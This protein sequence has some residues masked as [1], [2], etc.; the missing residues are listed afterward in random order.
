[1]SAEVQTFWERQ[2]VSYTGNYADRARGANHNFRTRLALAVTLA[3]GHGGV[4]LDCATGSGEI[5]EAVLAAGDFSGAD[6]VDIAQPMLEASQRRLASLRDRVPIRWTRADVFSFL[7]NQPREPRYGL[8]LC[9]G[10]IA[11]TGRLETLLRLCAER[12]APGGAI[13]LQTS[14]LDHPGFRFLAWFS[15]RRHARKKGYGMHFFSQADMVQAVKAA[16]LTIEASRRFAVGIPYGD[17]LCPAL[18]YLVERA[19]EGWAARH[20]MDAI[21]LLRRP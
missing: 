4:L 17:R 12:L 3:K 20:G 19:G 16:G 7:E 9:L 13:L 14:L 10:L 21:Y 15:A 11:H 1:M 8:V 6:I 18:N 2:A 5:T